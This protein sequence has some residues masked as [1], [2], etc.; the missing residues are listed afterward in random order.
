MIEHNPVATSVTVLPLTVQ[1]LDVDAANVTPRPEVAV[2]A[3]VRG[4]ALRV[5]SG[6]A[7]NVMV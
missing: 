4:D 3:T 2:A 7:A 5:T 6:K 1:T